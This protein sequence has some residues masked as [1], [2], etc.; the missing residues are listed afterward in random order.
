MSDNISAAD[1]SKR[2]VSRINDM[3]R[4]AEKRGSVYSSFLNARECVLAE[5]ELKRLMYDNY[6]F[7]GLFENAERKMLCVFKEYYQ[8]ENSDFPMTCLTFS[9]RKENKLTH[10]DFL[11]AIMALQIKRETVGDIVIG[12]G[13]AQIAVSDSVGN[14]IKSDIRK[15]GSV[16][17]KVSDECGTVLKK[18]Q[19]F[20]E[21]K[22]TVAS[23]RLDGVLSLALNMS[24]SRT[25]GIIKG[26]GAEVN[27][28]LK[29]DSSFNLSQGDII[30]VKGF[31]KYRLEEISG[32]TKKGRIHITLCKSC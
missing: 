17:V 27:Y 26:I 2:L 6:C 16:G 23:L 18:V 20:K 7:Y 5:A 14:V 28:F 9:Y 19:E 8:P 4:L 21:I 29:Y 11:G 22:G 15:I 1:E 32:I 24:R 3:I 25:A 30:S 10:R 31:G 12:D 13:T